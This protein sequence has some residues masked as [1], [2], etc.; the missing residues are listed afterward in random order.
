MFWFTN[1][2][3]CIRTRATYRW[4][5]S[6]KQWEHRICGILQNVTACDKALK[7]CPR[8]SVVFHAKCP[9]DISQVSYFETILFTVLWRGGW[10]HEE[11]KNTST[12]TYRH[13]NMHSQSDIP[14]TAVDFTGKGW[15]TQEPFANTSAQKHS[16]PFMLLRLTFC[17]QF[18]ALP[19]APTRS[20]FVRNTCRKCVCSQQLVL[21]AFLASGDSLS[22]WLAS[23]SWGVPSDYFRAWWLILA[24]NS[25]VWLWNHYLTLKHDRFYILSCL[26][27]QR[28]VPS[29]VLV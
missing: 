19:I 21:Q 16:V 15:V 14:V 4:A 22:D 12:C 18:S 11:S 24:T 28:A 23:K 27:L 10:C 13:V 29:L 9:R 26:F 8:V 6:L 25:W 1:Q 5:F 2:I 17:S 7:S 20:G 3:G